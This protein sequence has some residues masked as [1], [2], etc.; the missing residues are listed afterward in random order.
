[1]AVQTLAPVL[2]GLIPM[3]MTGPINALLGDW[4]K[5][6]DID[7]EPYMIPPPPPPQPP[8]ME[9]EPSA[10]EAEGEPAAGGEEAPPPEQ[11]DAS[12]NPVNVPPELIP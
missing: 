7:P 3:G 6:L 5:S 12:G 10:S 2:Q 9:P 1:M 4:A 8:P 11:A